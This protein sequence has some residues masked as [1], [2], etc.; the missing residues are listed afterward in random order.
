MENSSLSNDLQ[1]QR[2]AR[3]DKMQPG[4]RQGA[5]THSSSVAGSVRIKRT[6]ISS[7]RS[8]DGSLEF[9]GAAAVTDDTNTRVITSMKAG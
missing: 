5:V 9:I 7:K 8:V 4:A 1:R 6:H 2:S 3:W